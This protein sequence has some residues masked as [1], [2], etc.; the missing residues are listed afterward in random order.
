MT[1]ADNRYEESFSIMARSMLPN[2]IR[3]LTPLLARADII[4]FAAGAPSPETFPF[5]EL[6]EISARVIREQG[7]IALQYGPTR[8]QSRLLEVIAAYMTSRG[9]ETGPSDIVV[10]SGS[11][12]GLD[13]VAR[14][15]LDPGDIVLVELPSYVGGM[16]AIHNSRAEMRGVK[17]DHGGVVIADLRAKLNAL[18]SEGRRAKCVYTIPNFQ[19]PSGV[20]LAAERRRELVELADEYDFLI[21]EDDPYAEIYFDESASRLSPLAAL[22]PSRVIYLSSFSKVLAPGLRMAWLR[23][24]KPIADTIELAKEGADLSS[25]QLDQAIVFE[26]MASGLIQRRLPAIREFYS[27]RRRAMLDGLTA[28]AP[29]SSRWTEPLGGFFVLL[30]LAEGLDT[31][32]LLPSILE[33][34]VA[35]VPGQSFYCDGAGANTMRLAFSKETP[36]KIAEGVGIM[37]QALRERSATA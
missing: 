5:E 8:G 28:N 11:Q 30:T 19:N 7:K 9:I 34:G 36:E 23:A 16:I 17:Q 31:T 6:A 37:C 10:T 13:L 35:Y 20:T 27:V 4:S 25:S 21:I 15:L 2:Q 22:S 29:G 26:A 33:K 12:Q 32:E 14:V 18:R 3:R 24:P 1:K